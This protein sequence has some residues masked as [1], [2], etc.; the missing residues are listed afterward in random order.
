MTYI[1]YAIKLVCDK[2]FIGSTAHFPSTLTYLFKNQYKKEIW[3]KKYRPLYVDKVVDTNDDA[4]EHK[5]LLEYIKEYGFENVWGSTCD[6]FVIEK[7]II[8]NNT[9][10][11]D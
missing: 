3:L 1:V 5:L 7:N 11:N 6:S 2:Y 8:E 9:T 10:N 4:Y